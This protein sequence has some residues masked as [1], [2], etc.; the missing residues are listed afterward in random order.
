MGRAAQHSGF[1]CEAGRGRRQASVGRAPEPGQPAACGPALVVP[2]LLHSRSFSGCALSL[3][4]RARRHCLIP[5][6]TPRGYGL[7]M[8][9]MPPAVGKSITGRALTVDTKLWTSYH[10]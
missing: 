2:A 6:P 5:P 3:R 7:L 9:M 10:N 8:V 4:P 1:S